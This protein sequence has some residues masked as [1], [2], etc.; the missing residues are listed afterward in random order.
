MTD[1]RKSVLEEAESK[2]EAKFAAIQSQNDLY[3]LQSQYPD[4][5]NKLGENGAVLKDS[6]GNLQRTPK[7]EV[8][9]DAV[10]DVSDVMGLSIDSKPSPEQQIKILQFATKQA[11][12]FDDFTAVAPAAEETVP[13]TETPAE[14][15]KSNQRR[16]TDAAKNNGRN[17]RLTNEDSSIASAAAAAMMPQSENL[18]DIYEQIVAE[19]G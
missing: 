16:F 6:A 11:E 5:L 12:R 9:D 4:G 19:S 7:G 18:A 15:K 3:Q 10:I 17:N 8:F 2:L 1:F 14:T 13:V